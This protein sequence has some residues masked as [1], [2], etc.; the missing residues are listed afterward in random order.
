MDLPEQGV[1]RMPFSCDLL[2]QRFHA[3][4]QFDLSRLAVHEVHH[5]G[6]GVLHEVVVNRAGLVSLIGLVTR[7]VFVRH[8]ISNHA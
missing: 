2:T 3:R 8:S 7:L 1:Q 6:D 4:G 5:R